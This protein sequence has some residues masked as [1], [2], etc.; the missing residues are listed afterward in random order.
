MSMLERDIEE[1]LVQW[2]RDQGGETRKV[3]WIGRSNAPDRLVFLPGRTVWVE[4]K[5]P[6]K[7]P[8]AAQL[9]EH[10]ILRGAGQ[11]VIVIDS[12]EGVRALTSGRK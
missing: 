3:G 11:E 1:Y 2:V 4:C 8:T 5:A 7:K 10:A 12:M 6:G 9:R